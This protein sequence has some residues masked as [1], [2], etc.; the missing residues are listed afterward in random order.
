MSVSETKKQMV[1]FFKGYAKQQLDPNMTSDKMKY[2]YDDNGNLYDKK[3]DKTIELKTYRQ[4]TAVEI[5]EL[6]KERRTKIAIAEAKYEEEIRTLRQLVED[7]ASDMDIFSQNERVKSADYELQNARFIFLELSTGATYEIRSMLFENRY[8]KR[9]FQDIHLPI[10]T[11]LDL[12]KF[13]T[14]E[15][16]VEVAAA[17]P[18]SVFKKKAKPKVL[19]FENIS[20]P[21]GW[22][23]LQ[24]PSIIT[25]GDIT[26][27]NAYQA[28]MAQMAQ[29]Y[30]DNENL[31]KIMAAEN[32]DEIVY[33]PEQ[34]GK[35]PEEWNPQYDVILMDVIQKKFEQNP[36]LSNLLL[37]TRNA[38]LG[39]IIP[40]DNI[41]GI[42]VAMGTPESK[43]PSKWIGQ[44]K[45]GEII[46]NLRTALNNA[47]AAEQAVAA[48]AAEQVVA[49][50]AAEQV[51]AAPAAEQVVA[52][53]AAP[54]AQPKRKLRFVP[55]TN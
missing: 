38:N 25:I 11:P 51:V 32:P 55:P 50:P 18:A 1:L 52:A 45:L 44:N 19:L 33:G 28:V 43:D 17:P 39:A 54:A 42:G 21:V 27:N 34:A 37:M 41:Y 12:E 46:K 31:E 30:G 3:L 5:D 8:E 7:G 48:P 23:T 22:L 15:G 16:V 35:Q 29:F 47:K 26:Y 10:Y 6:E 24:Y 49:A 36:A 13:Y 40:G 53:P 2:F 20:D 14:R 4:T 9:K